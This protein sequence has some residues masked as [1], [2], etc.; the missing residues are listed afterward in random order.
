MHFSLALRSI[1]RNFSSHPLSLKNMGGLGKDDDDS[2][3]D[4]LKEG[5]LLTMIVSLEVSEKR[6]HVVELV[7]LETTI[8]LFLSLIPFVF[9]CSL[10]WPYDAEIFFATPLPLSPLSPLSQV[11]E[12]LKLPLAR[13]M[14]LKLKKLASNLLHFCVCF[15]LS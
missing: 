8:S 10:I 2:G 9:I 11:V 14:S 12:E 13:P 5:K 15:F 3:E 1:C 7:A 4:F 6:E